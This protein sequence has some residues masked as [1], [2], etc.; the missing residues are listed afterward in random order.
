MRSKGA[1]KGTQSRCFRIKTYDLARLRGKDLKEP[2]EEAKPGRRLRK[3]AC[4]TKFCRAWTAVCVVPGLFSA[5]R[6]KETTGLCLGK[7]ERHSPFTDSVTVY[8]ENSNASTK[9]L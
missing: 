3:R 8:V 4:H 2:S 1:G 6:E 5:R 7:E 9:K